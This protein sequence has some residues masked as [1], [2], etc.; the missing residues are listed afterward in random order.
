MRKTEAPKPRALKALLAMAREQGVA[1]A[2]REHGVSA[3]YVREW[4]RY[5]TL[6]PEELATMLE[7]A[8]LSHSAA[9]RHLGI[10]PRMLLYYLAGTKPIPRVV[11]LAVSTLLA[12]HTR[13]GRK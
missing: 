1:A 13:N 8:G 6:T 10:S 9:S 4:L 12:S 2:C 7:S 11:E 5:S 3:M